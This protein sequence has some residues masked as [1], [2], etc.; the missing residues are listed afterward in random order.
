ME[1]Y[2]LKHIDFFLDLDEL[3]HQYANL[4]CC[5]YYVA[6]RRIRLIL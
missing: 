5:F 1:Y 2:Y 3:N 4:I 6:L